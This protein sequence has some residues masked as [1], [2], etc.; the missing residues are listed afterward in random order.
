LRCS[1]SCAPGARRRARCI[2]SA[3]RHDQHPDGDEPGAFDFVTSRVDLNDLEVT[4]DKTLETIAYVAGS[5]ASAPTRA[6]RANLAAL[7]LPQH[8]CD[9]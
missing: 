2:V 3:R 9:C 6:G 8:T 1:P 4:I 7:L 5:T